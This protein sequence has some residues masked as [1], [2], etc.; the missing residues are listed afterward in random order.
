M[1]L[2]VSSATE[3]FLRRTSILLLK[4]KKNYDC[5]FFSADDNL[6]ETG[7]SRGIYFDSAYKGEPIE[8]VSMA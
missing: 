4:W 8:D 6:F 5:V 3:E 7:S 2:I 1:F